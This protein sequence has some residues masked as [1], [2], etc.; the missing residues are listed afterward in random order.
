MVSLRTTMVPMK[1]KKNGIIMNHYGT[2]EEQ[3]EW[4]EDS[5]VGFNEKRRWCTSH[6]HL[7][8][9]NSKLWEINNGTV[10]KWPISILDTYCDGPR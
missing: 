7:G 4:L 8:C 2:N 5:S 10:R 9:V 1:N 6:R 3:E